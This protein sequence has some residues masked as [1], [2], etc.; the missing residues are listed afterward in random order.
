M[1]APDGCRACNGTKVVT[2]SSNGSGLIEAPCAACAD[3]EPPR[4]PFWFCDE[5]GHKDEQ[6]MMPPD[7]EAFYKNTQV[8][9]QRLGYSDYACPSCKSMAFAPKGF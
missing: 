5:C 6:R 8:R 3:E 7:R 9:L 2:T 4:K 1:S